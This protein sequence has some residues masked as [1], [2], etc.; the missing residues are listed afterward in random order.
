ML[1]WRLQT[2]SEKAELQ[3]LNAR[4]YDYVCRVR[5]LERENLLLEEELRSRLSRE[6][7]WIEDQARFA[8]EARSLRQQLDEL[9]W[10][11]ALAEGERDALRREL[12]ELQREGAEASSARSRL[13]AELGALRRE[14]EEALGARAALEALLGQLEAERRDLDAAHER[15]VRELRARAASLTMHF[16]ARVPGPAAPPPRLRDVHDSYALL[17]AESWRESVQLY[18]DEVRELEQALLRGQESR[19]QA[20][21]EAR[22]CAQEA[23]ALRNQALELE[24]LRARLEDELL[25][26][27]EEYGIQAEER[28]RVIDSLE[29]EKEALTLAM[30]DRLRE[31]QELV[32]VKTGLSLEVATY[33][34]LLEGESNPE[35]LIWAKNIENMPQESRSTSY[36]YTSSVLQ[37]KNEKNLFPRQKTPWAAVNHSSALYSNR[38]GHLDSETTTTVG[39]TTRRGFLT[40]GYSS[41]ATTLQQKSLEKTVNSQASPRPG[42]PTHGHLRNTD[43]Q[44]KTFPDRSKVEGTR[45]TPIRLATES[46]ISRESHKDHRDNVA[47]G[48]GNSARSNERTVILGKKLEVKASREQ[49]RDRSGV[50]KLKPEEKRFDSKEKGSEERNLRWEELTKLDRD[51]R[52]RESQQRR[53]ELKEKRSLQ[54]G[55]VK[56]REVPIHL[57]ASRGSSPEVSTKGLQS[58][59]RKDAGNGKG[60]GAE[61]KEAMFWLDTRDAASSPPSDS[62]TE[63]VA[64]N[65]VTTILKQFTQSPEAEENASSFPD[66]KVTYVDRQELPGS[67]KTKTEIVVESKLTEDVDVSDKAGLEYLLSKEVKEVRLKGESAEKMIGEMINVGLKG[68]EGRAKVVNVEIVEEPVSYTGGGKT[69]FSTPFQVEEA[70]DVS[71]GPKGF[72]EEEDGDG[73]T[74]V[75]FSMHQHQRTKQ[76]QGSIPHVEE[77]TEAGGDSEGEQSYFVSTPDEYP[78][79]HDREDDGSVYGQIHI[80]EESTIRYSWQ[81]EI[82]QGTWRRKRRDDMGEEKHVKVLEIPAPSLGGAV[83]SAHLK[84]EASGELHAEPTVIEKEI[85]IPHEFHTSI[86]GV[87]SNEPRHQLVEVIGQLEETLP[88]RMK[89]ELS[90]LTRQDQGEPGSVSVDV[91]KVESSA[92]GSVTLMAEV[93]LSQTVDADQLDLEELSRDEAG[94]IE[95][96]VESVVRESLT[97]RS[98]PMPRSPDREDGEEVPAGGILFK[99]WATREL[100]S[101]SVERDDAGWTP[102]SSDQRVTQGPVSATVEVTS[103]TGFV[104]SHTLED[105]SQS[106]RHVRLGPTEM[107]RT[108]QVSYGG[109]TAQVVEVSEDLSEAVSSEGASRSVRH[110]TLGPRQSRVSTEVTFRGSVPTWREAGD[111]EEPHPAAL[112]VEADISR[113]HRMSGSEQF[114]AE[115]E[116]RFLGPISGAAQAGSNF[117]TEESVG[118]QTFVRHLQLG[119]KEGFREEIQFIAPIPDKVEWGGEEG[120]E[121]TRVSL[122]R[123]TSIQHVDIGPQRHQTSKLIAP[124][125]LEFR[126]SEGTVLVEGSAGMTQATHSFTSGREILRSKE[127]TFQRVVSESLPD[128]V[129]DTGA[130]V[131]AGTSRSFRHIQIGPTEKGPSEHIVIHGPMSKT[132]VLDGSVASPEL[133]GQ[134]GDSSTLSHIAPGPK[135]TSFTFQMDVSNTRAIRSWTRDAGSEVEAHSVSDRGGWRIAHSRTEQVTSMSSQ[136]SAGDGHQTRGEKGEEQAGFDKTVQPQRMVD[137]RSVASD[138]KKVALVYLDNEEEEEGDGW[139]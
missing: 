34:A 95:R 3:E 86:K 5:E 125:T 76:P 46:I 16:R 21:D 92:P 98:S 54:E 94:E 112:A 110:I 84:E 80:E 115:K 50:I 61:T 12:R 65:I 73:E 43:A 109:P 69:E 126:N 101:P 93:N 99:R 59:G 38:P 104:Q 77:V 88:E 118:T 117:A 7:L 32:Q 62:V 122:G 42:A 28:Q 20:E 83:G 47:A 121:H 23:D 10:S 124:Q 75:Q 49:E 116:I 81:D 133:G 96:A 37:R 30:A 138:E 111:T 45:D 106:V 26:M 39:S 119:P 2:G 102:S 89:E 74:H 63:T 130:E 100:Y 71:P 113:N 8:E 48:A 57:E 25:R 6:D 132:F 4:L 18:E 82:V 139:F 44:V 97:K 52:T 78:G 41:S 19:R 29:D 120:S 1:S 136:A 13:D 108:E 135:E 103:P 9:S 67:R 40:S 56:E 85:K 60:R 129:G 15:Q 68:R 107:W 72:V 127:N 51:A 27:Q 33:R 58:P 79:G 53:D 14:L 17:V 36:R 114:H 105:I 66:T 55:G 35:I 134:A 11:T 137:Q 128:S 87:F 31:Y 91:K 131:T 24:Q 64:E 123:S 22:L 90:A 70:D